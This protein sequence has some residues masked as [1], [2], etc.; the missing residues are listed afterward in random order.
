[1]PRPRRPEPSKRKP[2]SLRAVLWLGLTAAMVVG[3]TVCQVLLVRFLNPPYTVKMAIDRVL[4]VGGPTSDPPTI[5]WAR[6]VDISP[7]LRRAVLA[8][9]DQRFL[10]HHGFDFTEMGEAAHDFLNGES[11]RGASTI[12]MQVARTVFL[13]PGRSLLRKAAEAYYT[14]WIEWMWTK[15]RILEVYLNTVDW[16]D[17]CAGVKAAA[18]RYFGV[19]P[20]ELNRSQAALLA[21]VL[22]NP[23]RWSANNPS[24]HVLERKNRILKDLDMMP[25]LPRPWV[26]RH[27]AKG[28]TWSSTQTEWNHA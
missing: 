16:G 24:P 6:L 1:M 26:T 11:I 15:E 3:I 4:N 7:Y 9:E 25:L 13:W 2:L 10:A 5:Q 28:V 17:K 14:V 22:P 19:K 27:H 23:R 18:A 20:R 12:T 8:A 21:S